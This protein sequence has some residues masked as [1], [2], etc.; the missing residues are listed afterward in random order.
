MFYFPTEPSPFFRDIYE[1]N[2]ELFEYVSENTGENIT[3]IVNLGSHPHT[4][5]TS[6]E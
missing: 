2:R 3:D 5:T 1:A 4:Q 6:E